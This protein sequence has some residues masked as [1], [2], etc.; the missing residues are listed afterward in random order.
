MGGAPPHTINKRLSL[1]KNKRNE[2]HTTS[3]ASLEETPSSRNLIQ[4]NNPINGGRSLNL[5]NQSS[6][7]VHNNSTTFGI[8]KPSE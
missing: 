4:P 1:L 2:N 7:S 6:S 3:G 8:R 5:I